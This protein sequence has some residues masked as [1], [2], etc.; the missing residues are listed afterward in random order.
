M[1]RGAHAPKPVS[2]MTT[3]PDP[4]SPAAYEGTDVTPQGVVDALITALEGGSNY[5]CGMVRLREQEA[6]S[7]EAVRRLRGG[8]HDEHVV[9]NE[10]LAWTLATSVEARLAVYDAEDVGKAENLDQEGGP[11]ASCKPLGFASQASLIKA[12]QE[13]AGVVGASVAEYLDVW[14]DADEADYVLQLSALGKIVFG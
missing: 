14:L 1:G 2:H 13:R 12:V 5:W 9:W 4:A 10:R 3:D 7:A 6:V 8:V 11:L